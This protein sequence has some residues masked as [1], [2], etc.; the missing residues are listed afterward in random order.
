LKNKRAV[1]ELFFNILLA[2]FFLM[3]ARWASADPAALLE[4]A[5]VRP[6]RKTADAAVAAFA[7]VALGGATCDNALPAADFDAFPV[8]LLERT[9]EELFATLLPVIFVAILHPPKKHI[10]TS[11]HQSQLNAPPV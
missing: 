6:S 3:P 7:D 2:H 9:E 10:E 1:L 4:A 8:E 5:L 11:G